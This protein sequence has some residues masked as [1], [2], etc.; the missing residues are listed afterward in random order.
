MEMIESVNSLI[1]RAIK[2]IDS[3]DWVETRYDGI[4]PR[5]F[6]LTVIFGNLLGIFAALE[7]T[8]IFNASFH[9]AITDGRSSYSLSDAYVWILDSATPSGIDQRVLFTNLFIASLAFVFFSVLA[10]YILHKA[11]QFHNFKAALIALLSIPI[12]RTIVNFVLVALLASATITTVMIF[13]EIL[14][15][16]VTT[17]FPSSYLFD[18]HSFLIVPATHFVFALAASLFMQFIVFTWRTGKHFAFA[19][20]ESYTPKAPSSLF[21]LIIDLIAYGSLVTVGVGFDYIPHEMRTQSHLLYHKI[22][23]SSLPLLLYIIFNLVKY[24]VVKFSF[25]LFP[26]LTKIFLPNYL[27]EVRIIRSVINDIEKEIDKQIASGK[28]L[29]DK[30]AICGSFLKE[31]QRR[32]DEHPVH[33]DVIKVFSALVVLPFLISP[34]ITFGN[35]YSALFNSISRW[36][37]IDILLL[38]P[39]LISVL[40][41]KRK[42]RIIKDSCIYYNEIH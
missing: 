1:N 40:S 7:L 23:G 36:L 13:T 27:V 15:P 29:F 20:Q 32:V 8:Q 31:I 35:D 9:I 19:Q 11:I 3:E 30:K 33:L 37:L 18:F 25:S 21:R 34:M 14:L 17:F 26:F 2:T 12:L 16:A 41:K 38:L 4:S 10:S 5:W 42:I 24:S 6:N 28:I 39:I 22:F